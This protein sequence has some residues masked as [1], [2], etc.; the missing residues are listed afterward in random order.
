MGRK[1]IAMRIVHDEAKEKRSCKLRIKHRSTGVLQRLTKP[2]N[3]L[4]LQDL[5][6]TRP[7][8]LLLLSDRTSSSNPLSGF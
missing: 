2:Q 7:S 4:A 6:R 3:A 1:A 5:L 8:A